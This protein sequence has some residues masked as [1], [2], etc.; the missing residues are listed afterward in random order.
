MR[1]FEAGLDKG[2]VMTLT[3][4]AIGLRLK[5]ARENVRL[6]QEEA[7]VAVGLDRTALIKIE[8]GTRAVTSTELMRLARLYRRDLSELLT[9]TSLEEDPFT[10]LGRIADN[11]TPDANGPVAQALERLKE[12]VRL[13]NFL[14]GSLR[15][16]PP[17]YQVDPPRNYDDACEQ[18]KEVAT[19][20]RRRLSLGSN[21]LPDVAEIIASQGIWTAAIPL[22]EKMSGL[23]VSHS[24]YGLAIFVNQSNWINRRRFSYAHEYAHAVLDRNRAA[25][26]TTAENAK[27]LTEKRA[28]AFASEFLMPAEGVSEALERMQKGGASRASNWMYDI[29]SDDYVHDEIRHD[30]SALRISFSDVAFLAHEFRVSYEMAAIRLKDLDCIRKSTLDN[31]LEAKEDGRNFM[32]ALSLFNPDE[33]VSQPYLERQLMGLAMEAF[34]RDKISRGR[35]VSVCVL[36]GKD[37]EQ[38]LQIALRAREE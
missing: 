23:F 19:L 7:A 38:M 18:G 36:A 6:T 34:R 35:F 4:E 37:P 28:N 16:H 3:Q 25:E 32:K 29:F 11:Q 15:S 8:K 22:N 5:E 31:L 9:E 24:K 17:L 14:G 2:Q 1:T 13:E 27:T 30:A 12:A 33:E 20:E 10:L 26:P 21:A